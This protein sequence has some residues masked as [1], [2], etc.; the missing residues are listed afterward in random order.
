MFTRVL[1]LLIATIITVAPLPAQ[2]AKKPKGRTSASL[3]AYVAKVKSALAAR[4]GRAVEPR[5][6]EFTPG[7][8][9]V[10]FTLDAAGKV[11]GFAVKSNT[12]NEPFAKFCDSFVRETKF[13]A[14][15]ASLLA[16][17]VVEIPFTFTIL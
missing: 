10:A 9:E 17:G 13:A 4:W 6:S 15:P 16:D 14:P 3:T 8:L 1:L 7:E 5:M 12:S 2:T 11:T